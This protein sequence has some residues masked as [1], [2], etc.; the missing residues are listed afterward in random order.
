MRR[1]MDDPALRI[2]PGRQESA[3]TE[4]RARM[5]QEIGTTRRVGATDLEAI[6]TTD[7]IAEVRAP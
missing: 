5:N 7:L 1:D 3:P 2:G 6:P 4:H